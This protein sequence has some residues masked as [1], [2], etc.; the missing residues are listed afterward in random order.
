MRAKFHIRVISHILSVVC[1][2]PPAPRS[3]EM[4]HQGREQDRL[5][6][7]KAHPQTRTRS[8]SLYYRGGMAGKPQT[9]GFIAMRETAPFW[10]AEES[11][12]YWWRRGD[13][14]PRPKR[15]HHSIYVRSLCLHLAFLAVQ[16]QTTKKASNLLM[17]HT[18]RVPDH[19]PAC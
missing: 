18:T 19:M 15:S 8:E 4:R 13:S 14:N 5:H 6:H 12:K 7:G 10:T 1:L 17:P 3:E 16:R 2:Q 11:L 9:R